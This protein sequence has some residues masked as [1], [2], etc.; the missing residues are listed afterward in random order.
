M[1]GPNKKKKGKKEEV[2][3][4]SFEEV[5]VGEFV[6]A[7]SFC[8]LKQ[9]HPC[10]FTGVQ[11][12]KLPTLSR[13]KEKGGVYSK[14]IQ[15]ECCVGSGEKGANVAEAST[16]KKKKKKGVRPAFSRRKSVGT[17]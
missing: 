16:G 6:V 12:G 10:P 11:K 3:F 1:K 14:S 7:V 13:E 8:W 5:G 9:S 15:H 17:T 4:S 2:S